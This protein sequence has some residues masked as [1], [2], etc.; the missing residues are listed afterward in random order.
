MSRAIIEDRLSDAGFDDLESILD[1][2]YQEIGERSRYCANYPLRVTRGLI[3]KRSN[4]D[5][6]NDLYEFLLYLSLDET[7]AEHGDN[8][9]QLFELAVTASVRQLLGRRGKAD[10]TGFPPFRPRPPKFRDTIVW[11]NRRMGLTSLPVL[12]GGSWKDAGVDVVGWISFPDGRDN[13]LVFLVQT[14]ITR[15]RWPRKADDPVPLFWGKWLGI[16]GTPIKAI[17][18]PFAVDSKGVP[19]DE[20]GS[21]APLVLDRLRIAGLTTL[22]TVTGRTRIREW[23]RR[24]R[25]RLREEGS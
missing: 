11:L 12:P 4:L 10:H 3:R 25:E 5:G 19:W 9:D 17:A 1:L 22:A 15:S 16:R 13:F 18:V 7:T 2:V 14:T 8:P 23:L 24:E 21:R 6:R 20:A